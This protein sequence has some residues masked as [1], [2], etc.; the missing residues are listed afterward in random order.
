VSLG[1]ADFVAILD[2]LLEGF[3]VL[4]PEL[5][6]LHLN[7]T[8]ARH[9]RTTRE[10]LLGRTM[11]ECYPGTEHT[12]LYALLQRSLKERTSHVIENAFTFPD[13]SI[14]YFELRIE[15]V[16]QG[17]SVLSIDITERKTAQ[18]AQA[19]AEERLGQTQ[20]M[21]AIGRLAAG[22]AH[23]FNNLLTIVLCQAEL[24]LG[25]DEGPTRADLEVIHDAAR[26]S[27]QLT[28]QLLA[29]GRSAVLAHETIDPA[30][31]VGS[32]EPLLRRAVGDSIDLVIETPRRVHI[33]GDRTQLQQVVMNLVLN[34]RDAIEGRGRITVSVS[35]AELDEAQ[36]RAHPGARV[37]RHAVLTVADTGAGMDAATRARI[38]EPFFTTKERGRGNGLGL[39]TVYGIVRQHDGR[40]W[41]YSE[42]GE[43]TTFKIFLP[44]KKSGAHASPRTAPTADVAAATETDP[45]GPSASP[46]RSPSTAT[47]AHR[48]ASPSQRPVRAVRPGS[49]TVLVAEDSYLLRALIDT[50][51]GDAGYRVLLAASGDDAL[52][53]WER[54]VDG[55]IALLITDITMPG[56]TGPELIARLRA[57]RPDLPVLCTSGYS[58]RQLAERGAMPSDVAF[59][60]KPFAPSALLAHVGALLA[61]RSS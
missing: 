23:D 45:R 53:L 61:P 16:P 41:V 11:V 9:G 56:L 39:A 49:A 46:T 6:Y 26:T 29:Y 2:A 21:D 7:D 27:S 57:A 38:F 32:L 24:A 5:R 60:E 48:P 40:V 50:V 17:V 22:I 28:R 34:A 54:D 43:G 4:S 10:A 52:A 37:G 47:G 42:L 12:E 30:D 15:P 59:V 3:Q 33:E 44:A 36:A 31:V 51:L 58:D 20:R 1:S 25:R 35:D 8:A 13:G 55:A 19:L 14:G 18:A